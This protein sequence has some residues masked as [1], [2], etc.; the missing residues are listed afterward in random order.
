[1]IRQQFQKPLTD[2]TAYS[3]AAAWANSNGAMIAD[4]GNYY[5]VVAVPTPTTEQKAAAIR[6]KRDALLAETDLIIIRCAEAGEPVPDEWKTYRQALRDVPEQA[7][8]PENVIW[9]EKPEAQAM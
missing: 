6:A 1:M 9:P 4:K 7:G 3:E 2:Y 5:E 8:F